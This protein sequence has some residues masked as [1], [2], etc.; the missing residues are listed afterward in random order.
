MLVEKVWVATRTTASAARAWTA[1][2]W[3]RMFAVGTE[4]AQFGL[5]SQRRPTAPRLI[6]G[7]DG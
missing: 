6:C 5:A 1:V 3:R 4:V 7:S 2:V